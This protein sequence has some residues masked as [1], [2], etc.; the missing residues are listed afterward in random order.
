MPCSKDGHSILRK[1]AISTHLVLLKPF[2]M[3]CVLKMI[4]FFAVVYEFIPL[5]LCLLQSKL[6]L[7]LN[8]HVVTLC[9]PH[10]RLLLK[11]KCQQQQHRKK[12]Q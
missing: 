4:S 9:G 11:N 7:K 8:F 3:T 6:Q 12:I 5:R 10:Q 1:K 2:R